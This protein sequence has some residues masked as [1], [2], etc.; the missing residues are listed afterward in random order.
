MLASLL[1]DPKFSNLYFDISW[2]EV[3]KYIVASDTS[4]ALTAALVERFPDRFLF[5]T[6]VV[7]PT[8]PQMYY[9]VFDIYKPFLDR[10]TPAA[11]AKLLRGNYERLFGASRKR[12]RAWEAA[13]V[14]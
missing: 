11:R 8:D 6:D 1:S 13:H 7:A 2:E 9:R 4:I 14:R 12:V 10:L 5:G 3:A